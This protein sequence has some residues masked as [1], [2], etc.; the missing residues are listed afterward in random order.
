MNR[1]EKAAV[2][3][4]IAEEIKASQAVFAVDYRG[5]SVEQAADLR[6]R[7]RESG[8]RFRIVKNSLTE[9]AADQAG[10]EGLKALLQGPT[11]LAF[12]TGDA[13]VAA[14]A[15][16]DAARTL[17]TLEFKGGLMDSNTLSAEDVVAIA[18]LPAREIL[19]AQLVGTIAAPITGL[20]RGLNALIAGLAIQLQAIA[21]QGLVSG[22][23]PPA[24]AAEPEAP[25][26]EPEAEAPAAE[27]EAPAA[28][29]E[30]EPEA[31]AP[32][33]EPEAEAKEPIVDVDAEPG[34]TLEP[35]ET[36]QEAA[37]D[38]ESGA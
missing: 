27:P 16:N 32:A 23:A 36:D 14:K 7:L 21:D 25:G 29:P 37:S 5:I 6:G 9:R 13:A 33:A 19:H 11:A 38:E 18:R 35:E 30:P 31:E 22:E 12:V 28:E 3:D 26:A 15:L 10:A 2:V 8:T 34:L 20:V 24:A 4:Q 17:H 1:D